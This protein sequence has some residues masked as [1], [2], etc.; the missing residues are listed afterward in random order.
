MKKREFNPTESLQAKKDLKKKEQELE[1]IEGKILE[2]E[3]KKKNLEAQMADSE[4]YEDSEKLSH[5]N[6]DYNKLKENEAKLNT[7]WETLVEEIG[8]LQETIS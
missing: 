3:E 6:Q 7:D 8:Q 1:L 2:L 4:V 5:I